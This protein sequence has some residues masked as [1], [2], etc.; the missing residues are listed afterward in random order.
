MVNVI[1]KTGETADALAEMREAQKKG[2]RALGIVN[3]VGSTI[4]RES[5]GGVYIHA[6]P[7][8]GVASTKAFTS[9]VTVLALLTLLL[10]RHR[11][12]S[13]DYGIEI[14]HELAALPGRVEKALQGRD[15]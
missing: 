9:Q 3:V 12:L 10:G 6:G 2:T 5:D 8:I 14:A 13:R 7:E 11:G 1:S 4:A 15:A